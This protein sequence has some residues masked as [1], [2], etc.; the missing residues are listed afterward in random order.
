MPPKIENYKDLVVYQIAYK[1][2]IDV[3]RVTRKYPPDERWGLISQMRRS[4]VS[5]PS[6]IA[7]GYRRGH[8]R[9]Y[10]QFLHIA[11]GSCGELETL[12]SLSKDL[13]YLVKTD[14]DALYE[15]SES[16]GRLLNKLIKS[17]SG[18]NERS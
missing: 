5:V 11:Q 2:T 7:E 6:N 1:M 12:L 17:L 10:I 8:R 18:T 3:Y 4:A 16:I 9:E 13:G 15:A 14:F